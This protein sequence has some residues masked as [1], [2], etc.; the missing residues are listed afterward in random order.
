VESF[1]EFFAKE[2]HQVS[3]VVKADTQG[4]LEAIVSNLP[5][6]I[7]VVHQEIGE[8]NESDV[9]LAQST[10]SLLV[11]FRVAVPGKIRKLADDYRIDIVEFE[12]IYDLFDYLEKQALRRIDLTADRLILGKAKIVAEF[13]IGK[14]RIAG[15]RVLEGEISKSQKAFLQRDNQ[16]IGDV[17]ITSMKRLKEDVDIAKKGEEFGALLSPSIDFKVGDMILS[18]K[19]SQDNNKNQPKAAG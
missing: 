13:N 3:V 8:V 17:R 9:F 18:Y 10:K 2:K 16:H 1:E 4:T 15:C 12:L 5:P 14:K 11:A 19:D 7:E 6:E